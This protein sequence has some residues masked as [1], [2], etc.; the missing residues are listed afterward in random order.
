M[1]P[2]YLP[3]VTMMRVQ[4]SSFSFE[5]PEEWCDITPEDDPAHPFTMALDGG[6]GVIQISLAEWNGGVRPDITENRLRSMFAEYC[7]AHDLSIDG[8][9]F[10]SKDVIGIGGSQLAV[11]EQF[12]AW[13]VS[14]GVNVALVT[15]VSQHPS[16]P[17][18]RA[19]FEVA[20]H[21]V[22]SACFRDNS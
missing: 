5:V 1:G 17:G 20:E 2:D 3:L 14:N 19:E 8:S 6:V 10:S 21:V 13:Y 18:T 7:R 9:A 16:E 4:L 12:G 22:E 15:Y 11:D